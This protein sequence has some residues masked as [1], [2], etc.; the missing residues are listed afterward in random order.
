MKRI[1]LAVWAVVAVAGWVH[2]KSIGAL[3]LPGKSEDAG[4]ESTADQFEVD[5]KSGWITFSG[6]VRI[7]TG[8]HEL[9]ADRVRLHQDKGDVQ[10]RG[11]V[12]IRQSGLGTWT[13]DYIEYNHK[14]GKGLTGTG[15]ISVGDI[16]VLAHEV[17]RREDGRFDARNVQVTTCTN[18][19]GHWHWCVSGD[20]RFKD[21]DYVEVFKAVPY[22]FGVPFAYLPYWYRDIDTQYGIRLVPGYTSKWGAYVLGGYIYNIYESPRDAGPTLDATTH[23]DYRTRRGVGVGQNLRW[24]LKEWG[25]GKLE[26]YYAR[27]QDPPNDFEDRNWISDVNEER[28]RIRFRHD[29][30]LSPRDQFVIR[31]TVN[32]DSQMAYDF[33]TSEHR[34]ES[35]PL[36]LAAYA[37]HENTWAAGV[38]VSGPLNEFYSGVARLPE[39]WLNITPQPVFGTEFIYESQTRAGYL[40]RSAAKYENA[41]T[42]YMYYPGTWADYNLARIDTAHRLTYPV[43]LGDVLSVVP[44]AGFRETYYSEAEYATDICRHSA[45]LGVEASVRAVADYNNGY[46][47]VVEPYVDYSYQPTSFDTDYGRVYGVDHFDRSFEWFDQLGFDGTWLPYDWHGVRPGVRNLLQKRNAQNRM[48]TVFEWDAFAG[49]QFD[50]E[51]SL[52]EKGLRLIGSKVRYLPTEAVDIKAHAEWDRENETFAYADLSVFYK[53]TEKFRFGGGYLGRDHALY[54]YD[55]S[56]INAWNRTKENL[57][58][59]GFTHDIN[60]TWSWSQ[61]TRYDARINELDEIGGYI[62]YSLDCLVFQ[63]RVAYEN[64]Y[65]RIDNESSS[66]SDFRISLMVWLRAENRTPNDE[67]MRW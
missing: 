2:A 42:D 26:T 63:L 65:Q 4:F 13:G 28:Y 40:S 62:Q 58:Y 46:R 31:G 53:L 32:S 35:T 11:N 61:Y 44:R 59:G 6:N 3:P 22:L 52:N 21:N 33:F 24:D 49:V 19:P 20:G 5:Q 60:D 15:L 23:L 14:T 17:T 36:N 9:S 38:T 57:L 30:D 37:H 56:A 27:D 10:A 25:V 39:G 45:E 67:W 7:R 29:V 64:D 43:K 48:R 12:V 55:N 41:D 54:D 51:G 18:A 66:G 47:H 50:S 34:G 16:R 8:D 1:T